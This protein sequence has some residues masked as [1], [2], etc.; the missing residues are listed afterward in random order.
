MSAACGT[1]VGAIATPQTDKRQAEEAGFDVHLVKPVAPE[2]LDR[3]LAEV[4]ASLT[5]SDT[6]ELARRS[7][8][9]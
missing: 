1:E 6:A 7:Q 5:A 3:V 2:A 9:A 8:P 4:S